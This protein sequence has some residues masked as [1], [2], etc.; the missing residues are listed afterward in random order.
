MQNGSESDHVT[1][2]DYLTKLSKGNSQFVTD[3][4]RIFLEENPGEV[5]ALEKAIS[6]KDFRLINASAHKLRSTV[7]FVG[8]DKIISSEI[9][10]LEQ[11]ALKKAGDPLNPAQQ[12]VASARFLPTDRELM[13]KIERLFSKIKKICTR[14]YEELRPMIGG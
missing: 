7:P 13:K 14:A 10:E 8:I 2:L 4:I 9:S 1:N 3:M 12:T 5:A 11:L 6:T